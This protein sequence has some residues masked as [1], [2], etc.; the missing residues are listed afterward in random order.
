MEPP[1]T[2][3][4]ASPF[5]LG[6][7]VVFSVFLA[8]ADLVVLISGIAHGQWAGIVFGLVGLLV[9]Y[10]YGSMFLKLALVSKRARKRARG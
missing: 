9:C 2:F 7:G 4:A 5:A 10:G 3:A 1:S 8:G 6:V